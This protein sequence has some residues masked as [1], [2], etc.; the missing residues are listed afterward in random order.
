LNGRSHSPV[1]KGIAMSIRSTATKLLLPLL[2]LAPA[3]VAQQFMASPVYTIRFGIESPVANSTELD[4]RH[5]DLELGYNQNGLFTARADLDNGTYGSLSNHHYAANTNTR[6]TPASIPPAF[7]FLGATPGQTF[8]VL[9]QTSPVGL[10]ALFLGVAVETL[11]PGASSEI[12]Q[13]NPG[14]SRGNSN[15]LDKF[16][17]L[18]LVDVRAPAGGNFSLYQTA[19]GTP[20]V[21]FRT[22]DGIDD[23]D[24]LNVPAGA[25]AHFNW[26]FTQP[27]VYEVD[28]QLK[29]FVNL[30][31]LKGD[32]NRDGRVDLLD[33]NILV[34]GMGR[35][36][37]WFSG[38]FSGDGK[39][40]LDDFFAMGENW[41]AGTGG[42]GDFLSAWA[43]AQIPEPGSLLTLC[44]ISALLVRR[45]GTSN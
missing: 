39:I 25:H 44:A 1:R 3:A 36:G 37:D 4:R 22:T 8:W 38:D 27:G 7:S 31:W 45:R 10:N 40:N 18:N 15:R 9:P 2:C 35:R 28:V 29:T 19:A 42:A 14:D 30:N 16:V 26:A 24:S 33:I 34:A 13:W 20:T 6:F 11:S 32:A 23:T 43:A 17:Q 12:L 5:S 21:Y 41:G